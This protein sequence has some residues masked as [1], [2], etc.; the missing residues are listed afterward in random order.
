MNNQ[1]SFYNAIGGSVEMVT[2]GGG[3]WGTDV[4]TQGPATNTPANAT[5]DNAVIERD[6]VAG[7]GCGGGSEKCGCNR[8]KGAYLLSGLLVGILAGYIFIKKG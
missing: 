1:N 6:K 7:C 3:V 4:V 2:T 8:K 5:S